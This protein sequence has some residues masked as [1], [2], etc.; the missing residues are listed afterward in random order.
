[1]TVGLLLFS[2]LNNGA[3]AEVR[4]CATATSAAGPVARLVSRPVVDATSDEDRSR[5]RDF[6][7]E[8]SAARVPGSSKHATTV[9][10]SHEI[11]A[12]YGLRRDRGAARFV[13]RESG[14][15]GA[16]RCGG[17][18]CPVSAARLRLAVACA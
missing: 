5:G 12:E 1:M 17:G 7:C 16:R 3:L 9:P 14:G 2:S 11:T 18:E 6:D 4:A 8:L 13:R 10:Y 15:I